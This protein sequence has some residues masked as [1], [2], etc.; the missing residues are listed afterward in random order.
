MTEFEFRFPKDVEPD[1]SIYED[2]EVTVSM[3][4]ARKKLKVAAKL[5]AKAKELKEKAKEI[6]APINLAYS[7]SSAKDRDGG[8]LSFYYGTSTK[9]DKKELQKRLVM[10]GV[11]KAVVEKAIA[12]S[13]T[14]KKNKSLTVSYKP[15]KE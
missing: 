1:T 9:F 7:P 4:D 6:L 14:S 13:T 3:E 11:K 5:E 10:A 2:E 12:A 8:V 15:A